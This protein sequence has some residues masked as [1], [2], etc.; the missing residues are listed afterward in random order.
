MSRRELTPQRALQLS[1]DTLL[2]D[3]QTLV[4]SSADSLSAGGSLSAGNSLSVG[5]SLGAE[6]SL[7]A[8]KSLNAAKTD[9]LTMLFNRLAAASRFLTDGSN[10]ALCLDL[11]QDWQRLQTATGVS[12]DRRILTGVGRCRDAWQ[13][14]AADDLLRQLLLDR[15]SASIDS[16]ATG[17]GEKKAESQWF[18]QSC[19]D[20]RTLA[21]VTQFLR[22]VTTHSGFAPDRSVR[23]LLR[24]LLALEQVLAKSLDQ[25]P[26]KS[27]ALSPDNT[28]PGMPVLFRRELER[29]LDG[30]CRVTTG[31]AMPALLWQLQLLAGAVLAL[32]CM[33]YPGRS[34]D[35]IRWHCQGLIVSAA[36]AQQRSGAGEVARQRLRECLR[37]AVVLT[38]DPLPVVVPGSVPQDSDSTGVR[39]GMPGQDNPWAALFDVVS[40]SMQAVSA[41][42][43]DRTHAAVDWA[44][45]SL[46]LY[47]LL[48]CLRLPGGGVDNEISCCQHPALSEW[49]TLIASL[50]TSVDHCLQRSV[51]TDEDQH[52]LL[53]LLHRLT[54]RWCRESGPDATDL[55]PDTLLLAARLNLRAQRH[56]QRLT[57]DLDA[58]QQDFAGASVPQVLATELHCLPAMDGGECR[59]GFPPQEVL[60]DLR[61]LL[62]G[63]HIL[64]VQRIESLVLVLIEV[65]EVMLACPAFAAAA[66]IGKALPRAHRSLCRMLDQAAAWQA[67]GNARRMINTLYGCLERW[68]GSS[69]FGTAQGRTVAN[70]H[71]TV[72]SE[73]P[74]GQTK[75]PWQLCLAGNRRLRKLLRQQHDLDSI[76]VLLLELLRSQEEIMRRQADYGTAPD[77]S[78]G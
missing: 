30:C 19:I 25:P 73:R 66:D 64:N 6:I 10:A 50:H 44:A 70:D 53:E 40:T 69:R 54:H 26:K 28:G 8:G 46:R 76:R 37:H 22:D 58:A 38:M 48:V 33:Q 52:R 13:A 77:A 24:W 14:E 63:A 43:A 4:L 39:V 2:N 23:E 75:D 12:R 21:G 68:R 56:W 45:V 59:A 1:L 9:S 51:V 74:A 29:C 47:R 11:C 55:L 31:D 41:V 78:Q 18:Q 36:Q 72:V 15:V 57:L 35:V 61:L 62:K 71:A 32:D 7:S 65:Y 60:R 49:D 3:I 20:C 16:L 67:P 42:I 27:L 17:A 34:P 5:N